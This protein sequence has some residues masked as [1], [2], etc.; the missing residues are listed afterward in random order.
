M[1]DIAI[2]HCQKKHISKPIKSQERCFFS[3]MKVVSVFQSLAESV[4]FFLCFCLTSHR[5][6]PLLAESRVDF[7]FL[8]LFVV[9]VCGVTSLSWQQDCERGRKTFRKKKRCS[10]AAKQHS[11]VLAE[12][13]FS[14]H[15][16]RYATM[17][18]KYN[19]EWLKQTQGKQIWTRYSSWLPCFLLPSLHV[20]CCP[21]GF[22][23]VFFFFNIPRPRLNSV[24]Q[25][26][27]PF[28]SLLSVYLEGIN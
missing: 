23:P 27:S 12:P 19:E 16:L 25:S 26:Y 13:L 28:L 21:S 6:L 17:H 2:L 18:T 10:K 1:S 8:A 20:I 7:F 3:T 11:H 5:L 24:L 4:L 22:L 9:P 14:A 15:R